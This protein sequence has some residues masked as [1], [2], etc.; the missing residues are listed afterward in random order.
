[1]KFFKQ[2]NDQWVR[3]RTGIQAAFI[4]ALLVLTDVPRPIH[5]QVTLTGTG[6]V[7]K[8]G[9]TITLQHN[10]ADRRVQATLVTG[11]NR[12]NGIVQLLQQSAR[13][14]IVDR[15]TTNNTCVCK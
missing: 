9:N 12:G 15:D 14:T 7:N 2:G 1:V 3:F 6:S 8:R 5:A 10:A 11:Q 13:F 4:F